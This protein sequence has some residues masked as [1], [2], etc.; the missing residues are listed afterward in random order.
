ML[1]RVS[2]FTMPHMPSAVWKY[3]TRS[4]DK[5]SASCN[6]CGTNLTYLGATANLLNHVKNKHPASLSG[7]DN[8]GIKK[9]VSMS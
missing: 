7:S 1:L 5:K 6:L 2:T 3:F 8:S 4:S 9:Q